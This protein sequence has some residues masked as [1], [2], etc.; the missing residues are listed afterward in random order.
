[1]RVLYIFVKGLYILP[2]PKF[3]SNFN[4]KKIVVQCNF[5]AGVD[6]IYD[7]PFIHGW[8]S[9]IKKPWKKKKIPF[10]YS[11]SRGKPCVALA[12]VGYILFLTNFFFFFRD[13]QVIARFHPERHTFKIAI[14]KSL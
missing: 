8:P 6:F 5:S 3:N 10:L 1:M 4:P 2:A 9:I 13:A 12:A 7:Y 14:V 11:L